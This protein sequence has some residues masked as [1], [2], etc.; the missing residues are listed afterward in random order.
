M[1]Q[2]YIPSN[3]HVPP[4]QESRESLQARQRRAYNVGK[5]AWRHDRINGQALQLYEELVRRVGANPYCWI[6]E[7]TLAAELGRSASTIKRWMRQLVAADL[8]R[9]DRQFGHSTHTYISAY[10]QHDITE[11]TDCF[12]GPTSD[13]TIRSDLPPDS[14]KNQHLNLSGGGETLPENL[15][16]TATTERLQD[17]GVTD[18]TVLAELR[19]RSIEDIN[20]V[21]RYVADCRDRHDPRRAGLIVHLLRRPERLPTRRSRREFASYSQSC[22]NNPPEADGELATT[23]RAVLERLSQDMPPDTFTTWLQPTAL[24][25]LDDGRAVIGA[26]NVFVRDELESF[27]DVMTKQL[28]AEAGQVV[29]LEFAIGT[30]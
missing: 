12:V 6:G 28:R 9:R 26:P 14:F 1:Q 4:F 30:G 25:H 8:I 24:L 13:P 21:I 11:R 15:E 5:T 17:E 20:V 7:E 10:D 23:W 16:Q 29:N 19:Q 18:P 2:V 3:P 22:L 27:R